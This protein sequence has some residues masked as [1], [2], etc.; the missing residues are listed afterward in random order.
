MS[1]FPGAKNGAESSP[2]PASLARAGFVSFSAIY[3]ADRPMCDACIDGS[4][5]LLPEIAGQ[6]HV[7]VTGFSLYL[8]RHGPRRR[9]IHEFASVTAI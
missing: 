7:A 4:P 6:S 8:H 1:R 5:L 2:G 3:G 9:T